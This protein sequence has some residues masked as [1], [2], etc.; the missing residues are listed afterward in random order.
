[1]RMPTTAALLFALVL[2]LASQLAFAGNPS[3]V[4]VAIDTSGLAPKLADVVQDGAVTHVLTGLSQVIS[5]LAATD[6]TLTP[7]T[8]PIEV[9]QVLEC[10]SIE[11]LQDLAETAKIDLVVQVRV[12]VRQSARRP[13]RRSK[14]DYLISMIVVRSVPRREAW[15]EKTDCKGCDPSEIKHTASLLASTIAERIKFIKTPPA[16]VA[17]AEPTPPTILTPPA[18]PPPALER[19]ASLAE[20]APA[21]GPEP[22][23]YVPRYLSLTAIAGGVVLIGSG[24]YLVHLDGEGTCDLAAPKDL[25]A[26]RYKTAA[27]GIGL[28]AGGGLATLAG[29]VGLI[30][31]SP[32]SGGSHVAL[33]ITASSLSL[34]GGF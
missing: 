27:A 22:S 19:R 30:A 10:E 17:A 34:S 33:N 31:F 15:S 16:P 18:P 26:R 28:V 21:P 9:E 11:C 1:M 23:W 13:A 7:I 2:A 6:I 32:G 20:P 25:C 29:L 8:D 5:T 24:I 14:P 3:T 12:R 4:A